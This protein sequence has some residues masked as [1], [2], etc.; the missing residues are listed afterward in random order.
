MSFTLEEKG[1]KSINLNHKISN[2]VLNKDS[3]KELT[4]TFTKTIQPVFADRQSKF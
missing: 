2:E 4:S 1:I 3:I